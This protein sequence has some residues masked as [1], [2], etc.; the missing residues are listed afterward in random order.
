M[1]S[2]LA[3]YFQ[4]FG[5]PV[6]I[7]ALIFG[8]NQVRATARTSRVQM[9]LALDARLSDFEDVRA[10]INALDPDIDIVRLRRYIAVFERIGLALKYKQITPEEVQ[11]FYGQRFVNLMKLREARSI[12]TNREGWKD[13]YYLWEKLRGYNGYDEKLPNPLSTSS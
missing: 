1:L 6:A 11:R 10:K 8:W 5:F 7:A 12:V 4:I 9:L 13:F 3:N 2:D